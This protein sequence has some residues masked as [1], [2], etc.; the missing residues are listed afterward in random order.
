MPNW[1]YCHLNVFGPANRVAAFRSR[2]AG[3]PPRYKLSEAERRRHAGQTRDPAE[4]PLSFHALVPVPAHLLE[5]TYSSLEE[6][7]AAGIFRR[8]TY[9]ADPS[10]S[11]YEWEIVHWGCKWGAV[12]P[13]LVADEPERLA[14]TFDTPWS[15][16]IP[17]L[18]TTSQLFPELTFEL[19]Y[20]EPNTDYSGTMVV[21]G[22]QRLVDDQRS[23]RGE[24]GEADGDSG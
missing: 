5:K 7:E 24:R 3:T 15:P 18:L 6:D 9:P 22:G 23:C 1:C 14:Y 4:E 13:D 19:E 2:A 16:P 21:K 11:G 20:S 10:R 12:N 8:G 17:L